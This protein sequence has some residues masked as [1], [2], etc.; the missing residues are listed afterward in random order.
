LLNNVPTKKGTY[1]A[2]EL[3]AEIR[4]NNTDFF[5]TP[6]ADIFTLAVLALELLSLSSFD[7]LYDFEKMQVDLQGLRSFV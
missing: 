1:L 3:L 5:H 2:P 4:T 6:K 7:H